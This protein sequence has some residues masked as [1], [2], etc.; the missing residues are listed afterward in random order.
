MAHQC[1]VVHG[2]VSSFRQLAGQQPRLVEPPP[3]DALPVQRDGYDHITLHRMRQPV[4]GHQ[5]TQRWRQS[6]D[7]VVLESVNGLADDA[8]E[9][10]YRAYALD[11]E[12]RG[13]TLRAES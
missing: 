7:S 12:W 1:G 11:L 5:A 10:E 2:Q 4:L 8:F 13:P 3:A 6:G 9:D